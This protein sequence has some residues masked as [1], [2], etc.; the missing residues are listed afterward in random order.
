MF[1]DVEEVKKK[2]L[3]SLIEVCLGAIGQYSTVVFTGEIEGVIPHLSNECK[4]THGL[5]KTTDILV[6][7]GNEQCSD[8]TVELAKAAQIVILEHRGSFNVR[9]GVKGAVHTALHGTRSQTVIPSTD[10]GCDYI[11]YGDVDLQSLKDLQEGELDI[12]IYVIS[13][14]TPEPKND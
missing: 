12:P 6:C 3:A 4:I 10:D 8:K 14:A 13:E 2:K 7:V 9:K 11:V 1:K 5:P